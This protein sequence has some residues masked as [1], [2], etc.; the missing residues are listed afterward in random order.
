[1]TLRGRLR[2]GRD[3]LEKGNGRNLKLHGEDIFRHCFIVSRKLLT[4]YHFVGHPHYLLRVFIKKHK[5]PLSI[6]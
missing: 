3:T 4:I 2:D 5:M 6:H 1:M